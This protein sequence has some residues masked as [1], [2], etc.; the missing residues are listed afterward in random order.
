MILVTGA[1]GNVGLQALV[2]DDP[3]TAIVQ[4]SH[5]TSR[6]ASLGRNAVPN[7]LPAAK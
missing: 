3:S 5:Q 6:L 2:V 7:V 4:P 1:T